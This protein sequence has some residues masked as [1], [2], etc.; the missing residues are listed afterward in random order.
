MHLLYH[1]FIM[2]SN[3]CLGELKFEPVAAA[4]TMAGTYTVFSIDFFV[5]RWLKTRTMNRSAAERVSDADSPTSSQDHG[6]LTEAFGHSH[7]PA[8]DGTT[9]F[10]SPQAHF[11]VQILEGGIIFH[12]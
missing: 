5:M 2:F 11:D 8:P 4:I 9:D 3:A 1:A 6:K 12:S 10:A 7:G